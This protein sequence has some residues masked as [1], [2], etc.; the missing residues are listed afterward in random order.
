MERITKK[1]NCRLTVEQQL[2]NY[3]S[4]QNLTNDKR[5]RMTKKSK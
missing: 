4:L 5:E 2:T 1:N 3:R